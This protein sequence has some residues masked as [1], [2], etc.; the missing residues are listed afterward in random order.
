MK[1]IQKIID[2]HDKSESGLIAML[3]DIQKD[4]GYLPETALD[5]VAR[6]VD[7]PLSRM[8]SLATFYS[9]FSLIPRGRHCINVCMGTACHVRGGSKLL[10]RL[11]QDLDVKTGETTA[12]NRFTVE[13]VRCVG[14]CG[15]APVVV[16]DEN[17]HGKLDQR[18]LT[19]VL[20]QYE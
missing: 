6:Q 3:Q 12:D 11:E 16:I 10:D 15:L 18:K 9:A 1:S 17:F 2:R 14:C 20:N 8:Y 4:K 13:A 19:K 7:V 5:Q